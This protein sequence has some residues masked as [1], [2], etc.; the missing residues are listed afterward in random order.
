MDILGETKAIIVELHFDADASAP[1]AHSRD[2]TSQ[3]RC[4]F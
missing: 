1:N 3:R 2:M 4:T